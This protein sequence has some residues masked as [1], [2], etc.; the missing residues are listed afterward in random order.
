V[1]RQAHPP[2]GPFNALLSFGYTLLYNLV[3]GA[4]R[5]TG[6]IAH[7]GFFHADREGHATLASDLIEEWRAVLVDR[8]IWAMIRAGD[9]CPDDFHDTPDGTRLRDPAR[10]AFLTRWE[11]KLD[12]GITMPGQEHPTPHR[13]ALLAQVTHL[14]RHLRDPHHP[15]RPHLAS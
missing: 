1:S 15:Y 6:M 10:R 7:V 5:S 8:T 2:V 13:F 11:R 12:E 14:A 9:L 3:L 4:I